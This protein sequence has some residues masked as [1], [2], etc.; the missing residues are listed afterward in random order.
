VIKPEEWV[1]GPRPGGRRGWLVLLAGAVR[2]KKPDKIVFVGK[3]PSM[4]RN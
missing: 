2:H 1:P 3:L 4:R